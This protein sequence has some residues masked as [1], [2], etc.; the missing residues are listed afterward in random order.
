MVEL[1][2]VCLECRVYGY[3]SECVRMYFYVYLYVVENTFFNV[4]L[5]SS[6][7]E[8]SKLFSISKHTLCSKSRILDT[9]KYF[10]YILT[11]EGVLLLLQDMP[12][13]RSSTVTFRIF[14]RGFRGNAFVGFTDIFIT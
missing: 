5:L 6:V 9:F 3:V 1:K 12:V 7:D 2:V 14:L 4:Y 8:A 11:T 13:R 10:Q